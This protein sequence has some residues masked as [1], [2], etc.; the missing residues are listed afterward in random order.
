M[1]EILVY[2][3]IVTAVRAFYVL[4][5][6]LI[7]LVR[8]IPPL[9]DRFLHYGAR[10]TAQPPGQGTATLLTHQLD[11]VAAIRVPHSAFWHFYALSIVCTSLSLVALV[12]QHGL[13]NLLPRGQERVRR[14]WEC[15]SLSRG[16]PSTS[17]MWIG[18]YLIGLAFYVFA[19]LGIVLDHLHSLPLLTQAADVGGTSLASALGS[20]AQ[21]AALV[22]FAVAS[23]K[24]HAYHVYLASL[25]KYTLPTGGVFNVIVAPHYTA[26]CAIYLA[27]AILSAPIG[28]VFNV[29]ILCALSFVIVNLGTTADGTKQWM[30]V[31][32]SESRAEIEKRWRM[33]P[34]LF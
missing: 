22:G 26:E 3:D 7:L 28:R 24:Q 12:S 25:K 27:L 17:S 9:R 34:G 6:S 21:T 18:H 1:N 5:I 10:E 14:L 8:L 29:T 4:S 20:V 31:K 32:F 2:I 23:W 16:R 15:I 13:L 11:Q 30:V 19:N 33:I